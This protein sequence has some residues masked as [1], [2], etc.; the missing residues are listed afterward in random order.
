MDLSFI[1]MENILKGLNFVY[2]YAKARY[3]TIKEYVLEECCKKRH[4]THIHEPPE[5]KEDDTEEDDSTVPQIPPIAANATL[6]HSRTTK[7]EV[8]CDEDYYV[9]D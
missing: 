4:E 9:D 3:L 1:T 7:K 6:I 5:Y 8:D 2:I